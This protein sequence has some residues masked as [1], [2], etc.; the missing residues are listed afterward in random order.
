MALCLRDVTGLVAL[1][2]QAKSL[3]CRGH[4]MCSCF[5]ALN[6]RTDPKV[7]HA[8]VLQRWF[9]HLRNHM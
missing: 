4:V 9:S 2:R 8:L 6:E 5:G 1:N 7:R 3:F